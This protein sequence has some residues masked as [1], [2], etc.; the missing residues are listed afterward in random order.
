MSDPQAK[1]E[2]SAAKDRRQRQAPQKV[3]QYPGKKKKKYRLERRYTGPDKPPFLF[4]HSDLWNR[5]W[6]LYWTKYPT[7][8]AAEQAR[9]T[10]NRKEK[11]HE[12]RHEENHD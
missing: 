10:L 2:R 9:V 3:K 7:W 4:L 11:D 8:K 1:A 5:N 12:Y 6:T